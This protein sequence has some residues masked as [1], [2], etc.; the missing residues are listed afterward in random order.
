MK[1]R[2][3]PVVF[4]CLLIALLLSIITIV[5]IIIQIQIPGP[6]GPPGPPG[7]NSTVP[8]PPGENGTSIVGPPGPPGNSS[9]AIAGIL[10]NV[11][12]TPF[13]AQPA[14]TVDFVN[15]Y[16]MHINSITTI[17]VAFRLSGFTTAVG[18][19]AFLRLHWAT[20]PTHFPL[21]PVV[22]PCIGTATVNNAGVQEP[23]GVSQFPSTSSNDATGSAVNLFMQF[24]GALLLQQM[25]FDQLCTYQTP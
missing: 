3:P 4:V 6:P 2:S 17:H 21:G 22:H 15:G 16:Y 14:F 9:D 12:I 24:N 19:E 5:I 7:E 25:R 11:T 10:V 23:I 18:S 1:K 20:F 8:G 13:G